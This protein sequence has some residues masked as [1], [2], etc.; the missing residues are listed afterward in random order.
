MKN[1]EEKFSIYRSMI[2]GSSS[3]NQKSSNLSESMELSVLE[4]T[5]EADPAKKIKTA[6][7]T[8]DHLAER[9]KSKAKLI[10]DISTELNQKGEKVIHA[11][12]LGNF[13]YIE[14]YPKSLN[15]L[16]VLVR[17]DGTR[18]SYLIE[19]DRIDFSSGAKGDWEQI[20]GASQDRIAEAMQ[21]VGRVELSG[22]HLG[23]GFLIAPDLIATNQH[24][25]Q[26]I[27]QKKRD[28][29]WTLQA[30]AGIDFGRELK[31][32][33]SKN[34]R[35]F[36]R[37]IFAGDEIDPANINH[38]KLDLALIE[39]EPTRV[40]FLPKRIL[41]IDGSSEW[42]AASRYTLTAGYPGDPGTAGLAYYGT[43]VLSMMFGFSYGYKRLSPGQIL[44]PTSVVPGRVSYDASTLGGNSGSVILALGSEGFAAGIHYG[45][46]SSDPRE[47]WG[48][49]LSDRLA[50]RGT[51]GQTALKDI[52]TSYGAVISNS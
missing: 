35:K 18:P 40:E 8:L 30:N 3:G 1:L 17:T 24:V 48:H 11:L 38:T 51:I 5:G 28:G 42:A 6:I 46:R 34:P 26:V 47:N 2:L 15:L 21:C 27:G 16:E 33:A 19:N 29:S 25:L 7:E 36:K 12:Q 52:L 41:G 39:L 20:L 45:G 9:H 13:K 31:G 22:E 49:I 32:R 44:R 10:R 50:D 14:E 37:L 43:E 23:S 4:S